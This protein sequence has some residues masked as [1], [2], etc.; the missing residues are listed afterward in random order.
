MIRASLRAVPFPRWKVPTT[1]N[2]AVDGCN[3]PNFI[4][5]VVVRNLIIT[6]ESLEA[7][8]TALLQRVNAHNVSTQ[9]D[10]RKLI[11]QYVVRFDSR[12]YRTFSVE[13]AWGYYKGANVVERVLLHAQSALGVMSNNLH[14]EQ[15]EIRLDADRKSTSHILVSGD[16]KDWVEA[17]FS[18]LETELNRQK[19]TMTAIVRTQWTALVVQILGVLTGILLVLWLAT[20]SA[21]MLKDVEYPR[22]V[23]FA[24]WFLVYSNLWTY[25]YQRALDGI[26]KLF[27]NVRFSRAGEPWT[28]VLMRQGLEAAAI[29]AFLWLFA[30]LTK[31]AASV[32]GP[33]L[34][35]TF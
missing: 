6:D 23:S 10:Q 25:V 12:G 34:T 32:I 19:S 27:P 14:G 13:E 9:D 16:S 33:Y 1:P 15:I 3:M 28:E 24:F 2:N 5:D 8:H 35:V 22:A 29:A 21:P 7:L 11:P 4:R 18:A 26:D 20:L 31:W 30:W 17:T